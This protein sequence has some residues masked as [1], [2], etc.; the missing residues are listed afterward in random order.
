MAMMAF[1]IVITT[2][3][4][5]SSHSLADF[6]NEVCIESKSSLYLNNARGTNRIPC[7]V[8]NVTIVK[9]QQDAFN[10]PNA[11]FRITFGIV[12]YTTSWR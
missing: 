2:Y 7:F 8:G 11:F 1:W 6:L 12:H 4:L 5:H 10:L 3:F 9:L